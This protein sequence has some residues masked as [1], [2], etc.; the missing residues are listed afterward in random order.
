MASAKHYPPSTAEL[1]NT[2]RYT[3]LPIH[4]YGLVKNL[5]QGQI[6][7]QHE[8]RTKLKWSKV[9][10]FD[11]T[12]KHTHTHTHCFIMST[13]ELCLRL[14]V[15]PF[16]VFQLLYTVMTMKAYLTRTKKGTHACKTQLQYG[17]SQEFSPTLLHYCQC[18]E[19][20]PTQLHYGQ[21]QEFSLT[22]L[23]YGQCQ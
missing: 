20:S 11:A 13:S 12:L 6:H 15:I 1:K 2:W 21:C 4:L 18:Q 23:Q 10:F 16:L 14:N 19:F 8:Q 9:T 5:A 7:L 22:Q 3:F 17:Q